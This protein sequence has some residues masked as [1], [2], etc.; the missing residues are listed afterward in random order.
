MKIKNSLIIALLVLSSAVW[1]GCANKMPPV[2]AVPIDPVVG[3]WV[4]DDADVENSPPAIIFESEHVALTKGGTHTRWNLEGPNF[5]KIN[6]TTSP[7]EL[8]YLADRKTL[9]FLGYGGNAQETIDV[10]NKGYPLS[11]LHEKG[12]LPFL[13]KYKRTFTPKAKTVPV[14]TGAVRN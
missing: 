8:F 1:Q 12:L 5:Y 14:E 6:H 11:E 2:G 3:L 9:Y 4:R 7:V 10:V 13:V